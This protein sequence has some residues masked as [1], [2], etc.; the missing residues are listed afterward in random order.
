MKSFIEPQ[1]WDSAKINGGKLRNLAEGKDKGDKVKTALKLTDDQLQL[2]IKYV[3]TH[4]PET[5]PDPPDGDK[6]KDLLSQVHKIVGRRQAI[7][8]DKKNSD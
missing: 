7:T 8:R 3:K 6:E 2:F 1:L 4:Y 5:N